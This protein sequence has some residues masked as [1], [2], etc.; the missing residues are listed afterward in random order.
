MP[1]LPPSPWLKVSGRSYVCKDI[2]A[3]QTLQLALSSP[4]SYC[5]PRT[6]A[7][8]ARSC[9][10]MFSWVP[11]TVVRKSRRR[12]APPS[13]TSPSTWSLESVLF[14]SFVWSLLTLYLQPNGIEK[15]LPIG[16]IDE[17]EKTLLAAA[18]KELGPSIEKVRYWIDFYCMTS[19]KKIYRALPSSPLL[20]SSKKQKAGGWKVSLFWKVDRVCKK[21][22]ARKKLKGTDAYID[23]EV[24]SA[25]CAKLLRTLILWQFL[26]CQGLYKEEYLVHSLWFFFYSNT[27]DIQIVSA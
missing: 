15:I 10:P 23:Y 22:S 24:P 19:N 18:V 5:R 16:K 13:T 7:K 14:S 6:G 1:V 25:T 3:N 2:I 26:R 20:P 21:G 9:S 17:A 12:L 8:R 4:S 27:K 11:T